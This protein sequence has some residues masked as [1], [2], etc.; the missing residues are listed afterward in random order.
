MLTSLTIH[1]SSKSDE[2][3]LIYCQLRIK[4]PNRNFLK[5]PNEI[6]FQS[7]R[8][9]TLFRIKF[10]SFDGI[11]LIQKHFRKLALLAARIPTLFQ[12]FASKLQLK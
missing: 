8:R 2:Y 12:N 4:F 11:F 5:F 6:L 3:F 10:G 9:A 7:T 1:F